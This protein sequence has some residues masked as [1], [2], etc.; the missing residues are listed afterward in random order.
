MPKASPPPGIMDQLRNRKRRFHNPAHLLAE[1]QP[2]VGCMSG[3]AESL[4][5]FPD[6]KARPR[7]DRVRDEIRDLCHQKLGG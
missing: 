6:E 4:T 1:G 3:A 7:L 2:D 5:A